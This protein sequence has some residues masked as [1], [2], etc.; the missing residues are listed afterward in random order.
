MVAFAFRMP[1]GIPGT[2]TRPDQASVE[3]NVIDSAAPPT[4]YGV[5]V[6]V[7]GGKI[8]RYAGGETAASL[9]GINV[10]PF[11][12]TGS[13]TDGL[14]VSTPPTAGIG[15]VL[16][17]GYVSVQLRGAAAAAKNGAVYVRVGGAT[18]QQ[19]I[20][21]FEAA[22]DGSNTVQ[23]ANA[24]FTGAADANGITELAYNL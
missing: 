1:A 23:V 20:G 13:G 14:G 18:A 6:K 3:P 5:P 8:Q 15:D 12:T 22:A 17:R 16:K 9:Y 7:V 4:S 19:P 24:Y 21:G 10:R 11:P 2:I